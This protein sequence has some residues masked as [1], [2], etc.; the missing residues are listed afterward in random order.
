MTIR[1]RN[2]INLALVFASIAVAVCVIILFIYN[3]V[4]P[5][6]KEPPVVSNKRFI[7]FQVSFL[8]VLISI[9]F[10]TFFATI[11]LLYIKIEFE[12]TQC[13][14]VIYFLLFLFAL[15]LEASRLAFPFLNLW[16]VNVNNAL[17]VSKIVLCSRILAPLS[18]FF[19]TI[20]NKTLSRQYV[21][22]NIFI[23]FVLSIFLTVAFPFNTQKALILCYFEC[24]YKTL[25]IISQ[26]TILALTLLSQVV[27][28]IVEREKFTFPYAL[29]LL[30]IGYLTLTRTVTYLQLVVGCPLLVSGCIL[31]LKDLHKRYTWSL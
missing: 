4:N 23:L 21:E 14:E 24:S 3:F 18:L 16:D 8:P 12:K 29:I 30:C 15:L 6:L 1:V 13:P 26:Y 31:Y 9:V 10:L 7:L 25:F 11:M 28:F 20:Y 19:A 2:R 5:I 27:D 17:A 22:Q